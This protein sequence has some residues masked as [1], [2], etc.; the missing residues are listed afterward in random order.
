MALAAIPRTQG[1][2]ASR[3]DERNHQVSDDPNEPT[4]AS[5]EYEDGVS[6]MTE[7]WIATHP[8]NVQDAVRA[9]ASRIE[10]IPYTTF[11]GTLRDS[12]QSTSEALSK[13]YTRSFDSSSDAIVLVEGRKS[14]K[15]VAELALKY[16]GFDAHAYY[17]LGEKD[18]RGFSDYFERLNPIQLR[19]AQA[20]FKNRTIVLFDDG[21]YSG[22]QMSDHINKVK[23]VVSK[24]KLG[25][26]A[27]AVIVPYMTDYAAGLIATAA[28]PPRRG[29]SVPVVI[30]SHERIPTLAD[31][32]NTEQAPHR[33]TLLNMWYGGDTSIAQKLG[34]IWHDFKVPNDQSFP[35]PIINGSVYNDKGVSIKGF[36][37]QIVPEIISPYKY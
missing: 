35:G 15:W 29:R 7:G 3:E 2:F 37:G 36:G 1:Y 34:L 22:K 5:A 4:P 25:V 33:T 21:S 14:N 6:Y 26:K 17:H 23:E 10:R 28:E 8:E 31:I 18:A 13:L 12:V 11:L 32:P 16:G 20:E 27:I 24:Y 9:V 30:S 19:A